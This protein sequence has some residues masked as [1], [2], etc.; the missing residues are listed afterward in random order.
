MFHISRDDFYLWSTAGGETVEMQI[1]YH[2]EA[3]D[4]IY[5]QQLMCFVWCNVDNERS[6]PTREDSEGEEAGRA[7]EIANEL[8]RNC[9][10]RV[11]ISRLKNIANT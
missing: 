6:P 5:G 9:F 10:H 7:E 11:R 1:N 3:D 4:S 8:V 2:T